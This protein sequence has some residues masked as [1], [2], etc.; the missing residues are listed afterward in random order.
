MR[1]LIAA[2]L[3]LVLVIPLLT[4]SLLTSAV[5]SWI[6]NRDFYNQL[7]NSERVEFVLENPNLLTP[8]IEQSG[9]N[10]EA[11]VAINAAFQTVITTEYLDNQL[12]GFVNQIF[13]FFQG[14]SS[15]LNLQIDLEP[16]KEDISGEKK[17]DFVDAFVNNLPTC[18]TGKY[19]KFPQSD[20]QYCLS[21]ST[22]SDIL[23]QQVIE[24]GLPQLLTY[25]PD[26]INLTSI[27]LSPILRWTYI[28]G[29]ISIQQAFNI[30]LIVL[31][32][33]SVF[34]WL[35]VVCIADK[36]FRVRLRWLGGALIFPAILTIASGFLVL[37]NIAQ[38]WARAGVQQFSATPL[39][40]DLVTSIMDAAQTALSRI[41]LVFLIVGVVALGLASILIAMGILIRPKS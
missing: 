27:D 30:G 22:Q 11:A 9:G 35:V 28:L 1:K 33:I 21:L 40:A 26:T 39:G 10:E 41:G 8:L 24:E 19:A 6:F 17:T 20:L 34:L 7:F 23:K 18:N 16:I 4:A 38:N 37:S 3:I 31:L 5:R 12:N 14:T 25:M 32:A 2:I 36:R 29:G 15:A 13:D